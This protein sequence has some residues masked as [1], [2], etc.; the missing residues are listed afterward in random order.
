MSYSCVDNADYIF[1]MN[2]VKSIVNLDIV[3]NMAALPNIDKVKKEY[4]D[5]MRKYQQIEKEREKTISQRQQL[6]AQKTEN[7][8][9][10]QVCLL[11]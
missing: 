5:E 9:V 3:L 2:N 4:E 11:V 7:E 10:K 8:L 1:F 6:E